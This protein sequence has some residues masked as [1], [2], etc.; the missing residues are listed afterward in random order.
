MMDAMMEMRRES[1]RDGGATY[2]NF[3][4]NRNG[5]VD[6]KM[7]YDLGSKRIVYGQ[8]VKETEEVE[9]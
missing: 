5:S 3:N 7:Y 6:V 1:E 9:E 2:M 8:P 4:K